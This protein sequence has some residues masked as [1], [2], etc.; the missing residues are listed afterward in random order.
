MNAIIK[1]N[2]E[3]IN[4]IIS[5]ENKE[6]RIKLLDN[7]IFGMKTEMNVVDIQIERAEKE[8]EIALDGIRL[9]EECYKRDIDNPIMLDEDMIQ[10]NYNKDNLAKYTKRKKE[11]EEI[12]ATYP[13]RIKELEEQ[14]EILKGEN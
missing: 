14:L 11:C 5:T 2:E 13:A 12:K 6:E 9:F 8:I 1:E 4:R 10:I 7:R 3:R